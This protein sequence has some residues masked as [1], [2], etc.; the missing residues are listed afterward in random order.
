MY[1]LTKH[2]DLLL[3]QIEET[4]TDILLEQTVDYEDS[5]G[6]ITEGLEFAEEDDSLMG[7]HGVVKY[8]TYFGLWAVPYI[9]LIKVGFGAVYFCVTALLFIYFNTRTQP[10]LPHE[11]SA[12]SVFN[13]NCQPIEGA[14]SGEDIEKQIRSG[15]LGTYKLLGREESFGPITWFQTTIS[16]GFVFVLIFDERSDSLQMS[17]YLDSGVT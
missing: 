1:F 4:E 14:L 5:E 6:S 16:L 2:G 10:K 3:F 13:A 11:P 17:L 8:V 15:M 7:L 12:Y 9:L